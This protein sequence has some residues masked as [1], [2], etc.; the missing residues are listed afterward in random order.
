MLRDYKLNEVNE[1]IAGKKVRLT[2]W[3]DT[4]RE[5]GNV[6]FIDLRDRYGKVQMVISKKTGEEFKKAKTL[7]LES[8]IGVKGIVKERPKGTVNND[9]ASG[10]VEIGVEEIDIYSIA[11]MLPFKPSDAEEI[12]EDIRLKYRYLDLRSDIMK[13]NIEMRHKIVSFIRNYLDEKDFLEITTPM[14]TK[15]TPEGARDFIVPSRIHPGKFYALPQSPQQYKQLL[16]V[17]GVD[18][19]FQIAPCFRDEDARADRSPGEFFQLDLEMSFIEQEDL[20]D[21]IEDMLLALVKKLLPDKKLTF[22]KF[23]RLTYEEVMKKYKTDKPDLRKNKNDPNELAFCWVVDFPLFEPELENGHFAP[24]HHMFTRPKEEDLK[25]LNKKSAHK[26][27]SY[28]HDLVLNGFEVGG[29]SMRI[30]DSEVQSKIFDLIGFTKQQKEYF[31]HMLTAFGYGVPPHGGIAPGIDRL[32]MVLLGQKSLRE[33]IAFPKNSEA[34]DVLMDAPSEVDK[35]QLKDVHIKL[36]LP[37]KKKKGKSGK[38]SKKKKG[39][40]KKSSK[41]K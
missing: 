33:V 19:Y 31:E 9:L 20:L 24:M 34:K 26:V 8:C 29:G 38:K 18:K 12:S 11:G 6:M 3:V 35:E 17:S 14:L 28:Q 21:L 15:S 40:K 32:I 27:K 36:D 10:K 5:H 23:P 16:M 22:E 30:H 7:T 41:K 2:G 25:N 1:K 39:S 13:K 4:I 37:E